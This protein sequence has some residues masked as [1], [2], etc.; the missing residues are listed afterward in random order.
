MSGDNFPLSSD[1]GRALKPERN[2]HGVLV[3]NDI[4]MDALFEGQKK[5]LR[6]AGAFPS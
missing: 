3:Q 1:L 2:R 4:T 5:P 6:F